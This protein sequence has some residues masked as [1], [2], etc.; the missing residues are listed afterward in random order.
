[1]PTIAQT[2]WPGNREVDGWCGGLDEAG[3]EAYLALTKSELPLPVQFLAAWIGTW[4]GRRQERLIGYLREEN[5]VLLEKLG[6]RC[7]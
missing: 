7:A 3:G 2:N 1:V 5:R 4:L 6:A